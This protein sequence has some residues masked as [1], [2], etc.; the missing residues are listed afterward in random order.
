MEVSEIKKKILERIESEKSKTSR[1]K[2]PLNL[3]TLSARMGKPEE[4]L[5][6]LFNKAAT[7]TI[8]APFSSEEYA[9]EEGYRTKLDA[10]E[11][12][13][14]RLK[15]I[16][17]DAR[18]KSDNLL[19]QIE[20]KD[21]AISELQR[22]LA[23]ESIGIIGDSEKEKSLINTAIEKS[24]A[25]YRV[26]LSALEE[27]NKNLKNL[28]AQELKQNEKVFFQIAGKDEEIAELKKKFQDN[29]DELGGSK[30]PA[31]EAENKKI[32][33]LHEDALK[34]NDSLLERIEKKDKEIAALEKKTQEDHGKSK[35]SKENEKALEEH[36]ASLSSLEAEN[37]KLK[38]SLE[39]TG[40]LRSEKDKAVV[41]MEGL[42]SKLYAATKETKE[43]AGRISQLEEMLK[44]RDKRLAENDKVYKV[45]ENEKNSL[46]LKFQ[47]S[48][49]TRRSLEENVKAL[50]AEVEAK[51]KK[52]AEAE[53]FYNKNTE[54]AK[55][56]MDLQIQ[57]VE[58]SKKALEGK[59]S[60]LNVELNAKNK[61]IEETEGANKELDNLVKESELKLQAVESGKA[62]L[63]ERLKQIE[64]E[65]NNAAKAMESD[66]AASKE[67]AAALKSEIEDLKA[68][69]KDKEKSEEELGEKILCLESE[70][71]SRDK[72][73]QADIKYCEG[74]AREVNDLRQKI[75][76]YRLKVK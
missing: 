4:D 48:E 29:L 49:E 41:N 56:E 45:L 37:K 14:D 76:A 68:V 25:E 42:R 67:S 32:K 66:R 20:E 2:K 75:K 30:L 5:L 65:L 71:E 23:S 10:L 36:R 46:V 63:E 69:I 70:V 44:H 9:A 18:S 35:K 60:Q 3:A 21:K 73:I 11:S 26:K 38:K 61:R 50:S 58:R 22:K 54:S 17:E 33:R 52:V 27:E 31:L 19:N 1:K 7:E 8:A 39:E 64:A 40:T 51:N 12:E 72:K 74:V 47:A 16:Q 13:N 28:H 55:K 34:Q 59:I 15:K 62:D 6:K 57:A 53:K 43:Q 24:I